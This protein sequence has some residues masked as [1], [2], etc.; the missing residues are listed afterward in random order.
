M[1]NYHY[2][3]PE[4]NPV[5]TFNEDQILKGVS[6]DDEMLE[7]TK[8]MIRNVCKLATETAYKM[9]R[10]HITKL[11]EHFNEAMDA[12]TT[13]LDHMQQTLETL[14]EAFNA[15]Q[16]SLKVHK[17]LVKHYNESYDLLKRQLDQLPADAG[18]GWRR[19]VHH[20]LDTHSWDVSCARR[21]RASLIWVQLLKSCK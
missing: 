17:E 13:E 7:V 5:I 2:Y 14:D 15:T 10:A 11:T 1:S 6:D 19:V 16:E 9:V 12:R 8:T 18:N 21:G 3:V 20:F 4:F